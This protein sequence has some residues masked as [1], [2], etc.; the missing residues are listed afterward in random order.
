M[1][2]ATRNDAVSNSAYME[3]RIDFGVRKSVRYGDS[4]L[5]DMKVILS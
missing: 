1:I 3:S 4:L 5:G 2:K